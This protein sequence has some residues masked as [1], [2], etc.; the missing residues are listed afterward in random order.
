MPWILE[1]TE[2]A[3]CENESRMSPFQLKASSV[4]AMQNGV[5]S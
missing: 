3:L 5:A 1:A 4:G 2:E